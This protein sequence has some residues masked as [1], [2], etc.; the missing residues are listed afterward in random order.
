MKTVSS[1]L[2]KYL[3]VSALAITSVVAPLAAESALLSI[4]AITHEQTGYR[5]NCASGF[6]GTTTG[7]GVSSLLGAVSLEANDCITPA[8]TSFSFVGEMVFTVWGGDEL[9]ADYSGSFTPTAYPSIFSLTDSI[10]K[11]TGGTGNFSGATGGGTLQG[12]QNIANG[13]GL[14]QLTGQVAD[15]KKDKNKSQPLFFYQRASDGPDDLAM[16]YTGSDDSL[17]PGSTTLGDYFY[18]DQNGQLLAINALP[19]SSS[20]SLLAVGFISFMV[21]RRRKISNS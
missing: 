15:F 13:I 14:I 8:A 5:P 7:A 2:I 17:F 16:I 21:M 11:I 9:F 4:S 19:I 1:N 3:V 20:L 12:I 10:F 18:Q 6:G